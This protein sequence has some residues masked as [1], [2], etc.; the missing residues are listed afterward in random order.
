M[1]EVIGEAPQADHKGR[2][3]DSIA[4]D[5]GTTMKMQVLTLIGAAA[6]LAV[7]G[8]A[9]A[10]EPT[11][12]VH[13][14]FAFTA[15]GDAFP[16]GTYA[17]QQVD[18]LDSSALVIRNEDNRESAFV[19]TLPRPAVHNHMLDKLFFVKEGPEFVLRT[20]RLADSEVYTLPSVM[21]KH[22]GFRTS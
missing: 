1:G 10:D 19:G 17:I 18:L 14:P 13:V 4:N 15:E 12:V 3:F 2:R 6:F 22:P 9:R 16:A 20:I 21:P 8:N 11:A 5:G 7:A